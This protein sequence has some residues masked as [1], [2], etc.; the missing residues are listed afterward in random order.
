MIKKYFLILT[1]T[2]IFLFIG[3]TEIQMFAHQIFPTNVY[4]VDAVKEQPW[5]NH[6][7][8]VES[9]PFA[10]YRINLEYGLAWTY[11]LMT[12]NARHV[13]NRCRRYLI[14]SEAW[15]PPKI[16]ARPE[17]RRYKT[18]DKGTPGLTDGFD[19]VKTIICLQPT[20][21]IISPGTIMN[22]SSVRLSTSESLEDKN[23]RYVLLNHGFTYGTRIP[24]SEDPQWFS[25]D[26]RMGPSSAEKISETQRRIEVPW[27]YLILN[28]VKNE[29]VITTQEK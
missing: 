19:I 17:E 1:I 15:N 26:L 21:V 25:P 24:Y 18:Y 23:E 7:K 27:G 2:P 8:Q 28:K 9:K 4:Y 16:V 12:F 22:R 10:I 29:W 6:N 13:A 5:I 20:I 3:C 11:G 14:R